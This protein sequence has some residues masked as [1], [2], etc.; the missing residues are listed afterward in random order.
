MLQYHMLI[1]VCGEDTAASRE[2]LQ[3]LKEDYRKKEYAVYTVRPPELSEEYKN[4]MQSSTLFNLHKVF[5]V[6]NLGAALGRKVD[7]F[8]KI[9]ETIHKDTAITVINWESK[10]SWEL[11]S[12]SYGTLKE[13]KPAGSIFELLDSCYPGNL[14]T[15]VTQLNTVSSY[16]DEIFIF[17]LLN[18]QIRSLIMA[19][20][21]VFPSTVAP[22]QRGKLASI[23][24]RWEKEKL[25]GF[26]EGLYRIDVSLKT[27]NNAYGLRKSLE[28]LS[29]YY[30]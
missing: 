23:A 24:K 8:K 9:V 27:S 12:K 1:T 29:C 30:L 10:S 7:A 15:F 28:L 20:N 11:K 26:Y 25:S 6:E 5:F 2:Y 4:D 14:K 22:W 13:F 16:Q 19:H 18:R 3:K 21:N 17:T